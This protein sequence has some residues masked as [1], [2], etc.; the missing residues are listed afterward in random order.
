MNFETFA[1]EIKNKCVSLLSEPE[2]YTVTLHQITKNN[3]VELTG[4]MIRHNQ[5]CIA[6]NIY[7]DQYYE[8]YQRGTDLDT[9][10][11]QIMNCISDAVPDF[12]ITPSTIMD[13]ATIKSQI[14][15]QLVNF[16]RNQKQLQDC[17]YLPFCDLAIVF[18]WLVHSDH[19]GIASSLITN[20]ELEQWNINIQEL[21]RVALDNTIRLFPQEF[22]P[23]QNIL[24][25]LLGDS[26]LSDSTPFEKQL[27][28]YVLTNHS[29]INGSVCMLYPHALEM[30]SNLLREDLY[31]LPSSIHE[32]LILPASTEF[33]ESALLQLVKDANQSVVSPTEILSDSIYRY[34]YSQKRVVQISN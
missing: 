11:Q 22:S 30:V 15:L 24:N 13:F 1:N 34:V 25:Q 28:L 33:D 32:V 3:N 17:P 26:S 27:S 29:H 14:I 19:S 8:S 7:L 18:R 5:E 21:Y 9:I 4:I 20:R 23:L 10:A 6:P 16:N 2:K 12:D 31:I